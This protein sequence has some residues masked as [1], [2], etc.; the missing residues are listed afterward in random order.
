M[1]VNLL[2]RLGKAPLRLLGYPLFFQLAF[3]AGIYL[4]FPYD[5]LRDRIVAEAE[6]ATAM[7]VAIEKVRL[8][9]V[10]G[11]TLH[12]LLL[13]DPDSAAA[14]E[15]SAA[16][17][18]E[19]EGEEAPPL[20]EPK[21]LY[22]DRVTARAD[23]LALVLGRRAVRFDVDAFGGHLEGRLE[24]GDEE[25][26]LTARATDL[27]FAQ[28]P[29]KAFA[30]LDLA[31]RLE[32]IEVDL[33]SP[34]AD[35][36]RADGTIRVSGDELLLAGGEVQM[37]EL[38]RVALGR[39]EGQL[40]FEKGVATFESFRLEGADLQAEIE[41]N[42]RLQSSLRNSSLTGKLRLKPSDDWWNRNEMLKT[43][44]NFALPADK[45]GW[46]SISIYGLLGAPR[47]RPMK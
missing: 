47:F 14:A 31:G 40:T 11:L 35:F 34:G 7:D 21:R 19:A 26:V 23:L 18:E 29:L 27:D 5:Q 16:V 1:S 39:L 37:F 45:D 46:R 33:R 44:A 3:L 41:G 32:A 22:L 36:S 43:A 8:S 13:A 9:G 4:T 6:K 2:S 28:S 15:A 30:G 24:M 25:Q 42:L 20:P 12:G 10:S 17:A 38:P